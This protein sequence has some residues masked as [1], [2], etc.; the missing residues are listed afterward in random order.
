MQGNF[1]EALLKPLLFKR[2]VIYS[3]LTLLLGS[4]Q[5]SFFPLLKICPSTPD[6]IMGM[7]LAVMLIDSQKCAAVL[8]ICAGFFIDAIGGGALAL[9]PLVYLFFVLFVGIFSRKMLTSFASYAI[10]ML[11]MLAYRA[12]ATALCLIIVSDASLSLGSV[13]GV[14]MSELLCTA[15][16]CLPLYAIVRICA[17]PLDNHTKFTF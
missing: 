9:S 10:L 3:I 15:I 17:A 12:I 2:I 8:A 11:P 1:R 16:L 5:C 14:V 7:I 13:L 6:L 4:A